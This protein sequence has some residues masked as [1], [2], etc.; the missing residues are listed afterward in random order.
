M[1][2]READEDLSRMNKNVLINDEMRD[3]HAR[4]KKHYYKD[5]LLDQIAEND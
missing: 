4:A 1:K 5:R 3:A 2:E